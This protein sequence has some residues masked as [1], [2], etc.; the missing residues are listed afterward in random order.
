MTRNSTLPVNKRTLFYIKLSQ[1]S[2]RDY[3][4]SRRELLEILFSLDASVGYAS[5]IISESLLR[6]VL[7]R[8]KRGVY[9]INQEKLREALSLPEKFG[10]LLIPE[11]ELEKAK[12]RK[13][14]EKVIIKAIVREEDQHD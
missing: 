1:A 9:R 11:E 12:N 5:N 10:I 6:G 2:A 7:T 14:N 4:I 8:E 3:T 13:G